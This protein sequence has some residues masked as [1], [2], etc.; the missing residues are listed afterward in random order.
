MEVETVTTSDRSLL[1][2]VR[3]T[4]DGAEEAFLCVA[5]VQEKGIHLLEKELDGLRRRQAHSRLLVTTTFQTTSDSA[6]A[7][8]TASASRFAS[9]TRVPARPSI[10]ISATPAITRRP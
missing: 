7:W 9:S 3:A 6:L 10:P 4:L 5:F 8:R 2:A 1:H